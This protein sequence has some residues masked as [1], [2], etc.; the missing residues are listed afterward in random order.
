[1]K[2]QYL[3]LCLILLLSLFLTSCGPGHLFGPTV[4]P[5][6]TITPSPTTT[7]TPTITP[8]PTPSNAATTKQ[9]FTPKPTPVLELTGRCRTKEQMIIIFSEILGG[10]KKY[11]TPSSTFDCD[12]EWIY[13]DSD[14]TVI[15]AFDV[16]NGCAVNAQ[17]TCVS[18]TTDLLLSEGALVNARFRD[19][20]RGIELINRKIELDMC[21]CLS[22][23]DENTYRDYK[24]QLWIS[25]C[26]CTGDWFVQHSFVGVTGG[27]PV[28]NTAENWCRMVQR[29]YQQ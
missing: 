2:K 18:D 21:N 13:N 6:Y 9:T 26:A 23:Y 12:Y 5:T 17:I 24:G 19:A 11:F 15:F 10:E 3:S 28:V 20:F 4:T 8:S 25:K 1:M 29:A 22:G 14:I 7:N 16:E 27:L